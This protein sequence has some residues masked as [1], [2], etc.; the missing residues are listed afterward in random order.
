MKHCLSFVG[1][2]FSFVL[3]HKL[4]SGAFSDCSGMLPVYVT[5]SGSVLRA[6]PTPADRGTTPMAGGFLYYQIQHVKTFRDLPSP[7]LKCSFAIDVVPLYGEHETARLESSALN[8]IRRNNINDLNLSAGVDI[9]V[10]GSTYIDTKYALRHLLIVLYI[11]MCTFIAI[12]FVRKIRVL[13]RRRRNLC[14]G[15]GYPCESC[16][17]MPCPECGEAQR[18]VA[19]K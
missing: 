10:V 17:S 11:V 15:C 16:N 7:V 14:I 3:L 9:T 12:K 13:L 1:I 18:L 2:L 5:N 8:W 19:S 4:S 6:S